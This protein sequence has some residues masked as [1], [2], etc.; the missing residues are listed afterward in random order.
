MSKSI[1]HSVKPVKQGKENNDTAETN[2][3]LEKIRQA[4]ICRHYEQLRDQGL[5][6]RECLKETADFARISE[7]HAYGILTDQKQPTGRKTS[8]VSEYL[9]K[10]E[11]AAIKSNKAENQKGDQIFEEISR[12]IQNDPNLNEEEKRALK[13]ELDSRRQETEALLSSQNTP[14]EESQFKSIADIAKNAKI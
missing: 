8:S 7:R 11:E 3:G 4:G 1:P 5:S 13:A 9:G 6:P 14:P 12:E 10:I 2:T